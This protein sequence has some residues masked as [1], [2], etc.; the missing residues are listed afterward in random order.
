MMSLSGDHK[1]FEEG[2]HILYYLLGTEGGMKVKG[3]P[4][5]KIIMACRRGGHHALYKHCK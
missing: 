4:C 1:F 3:S 5:P 2:D